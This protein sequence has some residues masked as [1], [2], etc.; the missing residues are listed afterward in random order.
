MFYTFQGEKICFF[1]ILPQLW[2]VTRKKIKNSSS[3]FFK[4]KKTN[5]DLAGHKTADL[6]SYNLSRSQ[7]IFSIY[8]FVV[9]VGVAREPAQVTRRSLRLPALTQINP[10][11]LWPR[12]CCVFRRK[13]GYNGHMLESI[14][15]L[16]HSLTLFVFRLFVNQIKIR[17]TKF[18]S[19][20]FIPHIF[21]V[22]PSM[23]ESGLTKSD[24]KMQNILAPLKHICAVFWVTA[25][26]VT[27]LCLMRTHFII[28]AGIWNDIR[29]WAMRP[30]QRENSSKAAHSLCFMWSCNI[31]ANLMFGSK[32]AMAAM[33]LYYISLSTRPLIGQPGGR[34]WPGEPGAWPHSG[35][36]RLSNR[37]SRSGLHSVAWV[38]QPAQILSFNSQFLPHVPD[39]QL[40]WAVV[41][42]TCRSVTRISRMPVLTVAA[43]RPGPGR[44]LLRTGEPQLLSGGEM[45]GGERML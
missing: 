26:L 2:S 33:T 11:Q 16:T 28:E 23:N 12:P 9:C 19:S 25:N 37:M 30:Q 1:P 38:T 20:Y 14:P 6:P 34:T 17:K 41:S 39:D 44:A 3:T 10:L 31:F 27:S 45:G 13:H 18:F 42:A 32:G 7:K 21:L 4:I 40:V 5:F 22:S 8:Q 15:A 36:S 43:A 35:H 29:L 24:H